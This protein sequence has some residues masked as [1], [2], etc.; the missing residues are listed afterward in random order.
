MRFIALLPLLILISAPAADAQ[1]R[2]RAA[3]ATSTLTATVTDG[4]GL[5]LQGVQVTVTGPLEREGTTLPN[6]VVRFL[7]M[8]AGQYRLRFAYEKFVLLERDVTIRA[9]AP[10]AIDVMLTRAPEPE[11]PPEPEKP[12][13]A[14]K[15]A[16]PPGDP[17]VV[18]LVSFIERN[19][20]SSRD[21]MKRDEL[22]CTASAQTTLLQIRE[23]VP[24][25]ALPDADE[26]LYVVAGEG[27]LRLGN[28]DVP[29]SGSTMAVVPRGTVRGLTRSGRNPLIVLSVVSG[30]ACTASSQ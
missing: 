18:E 4:G 28:R 19:F 1:Q 3:A 27:T 11:A 16:A 8:R 5:P 25:R 12:A 2:S 29:L 14:P 22:G 30:P 24:E 6:G 7:N 17:N 20:I 21:Q 26:V 13:E 23:P 10:L 15:E 9:G